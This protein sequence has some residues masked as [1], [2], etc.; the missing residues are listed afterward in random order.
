MPNNL[1]LVGAQ[2]QKPTRWAPLYTGRF[3]SGI[4]TNRSPLRDAATTRNTEKY[5][6]PA[7]D[8]LITGLNTEVTN[9]LTLARRAGTSEYDT[10][11]YTGVDRFYEFRLFDPTTEQI[12]VMVDQ[13][14]AL[15]SLNSGVKSLVFTKSANAG[16]SYMQSVGNILYFA[17]GVDNKKWLQSLTQ[18]TANTLW[19]QPGTPFFTTFLID[20]NGNIQQLTGSVFPITHVT[21]SNNELTITSSATLT[22]LSAVGDI[23][24]FPGAMTAAFLDNK[25][26]TIDSVT[27]NTFTAPFTNPDYSAA[28]TATG[29]AINGGTPTSGGTVPTWSTVVPS[30]SNNFQGGI[31]IDGSVQWTNRG[32]PVENW[33]IAPPTTVL[34]PTK[35]AAFSATWTKNTYYSLAGAI[36]DTN[37]NLQQVTTAGTSSSSVPTWNVTLFGTTTDNG[38]TWTMIQ[39]AAQLVWQAGF[40]YKPPFT[41]SECASAVSGNT[42]YTGV[43]A[44]GAANAYVGMSFLITGFTDLSN[45]GVFNCTASTATTLQLAN[46]AGVAQSATNTASAVHQGT[47]QYVIGNAAGTNCLFKL[48]PATAPALTGSVSAFL[49]AAPHSGPV[50]QFI[51]TNPTSTGSALASSLT[52]NS[53]DFIGTPLGTGSTLAWDTINGAGTVV[54]TTNPFPAFVDNYQLIIEATLNVPVAGQYTFTIVHHDGMIWG[55]GGGVT[56]VSGT[57]NNPIGQ[58]LTAANGYPVLGGTNLSLSGGLE[59]TDTFTVVFPTAGTYPIEIDYDYW[60]HSGQKLNVTCNGNVLANGTVTS[61]SVQPTWPGFNTSFA[62]GYASVSES[63]GGI[64]WNN[65]GPVLD[66]VWTASKGFSLPDSIITDSNGFGEAPYRSGTSGTTQPVWS[67]GLYQLTSDSPNLIWINEGGGSTL[68]AGSLSTFNG[69][70]EYCLALVN[71][72]DNTVSNCTRL[73][74][75]TGN[76]AGLSSI[77]LAPGDGLPP[78]ASIDSQSDY[79]AIFRTTDGQAV[80]FLIP[81][82]STVYTIS[83]A[84]YI[85]NGYTDTTPDTGL[86]N[87]IEGAILGENTPPAQ[88]AKN[89]AYHLNRI[90]YSVGNVVY[91]TSGPDTPVGNGLNGTSPLNFDSMPSLV[92]RIIPTTAGAMIFTVSDVY[93]IQ[94][95]GVANNPLQGAVPILPGIG[96][97]SYNA[98]DIN[99]PLIGLF[100]TDNQ[101]IVL[102]PAGGTDYAGFPIGD[103]FRLNNGTPGQSWNPANVYVAWHVQAEDQGWYICDGVN[104]WYRLMPT[105]SP[106]VGYTWCPF[107]SIVGG[108]KAVQS[109]EVTPGQHRLLIG[110]VTTGSILQRDLTVF[111]DNGT[112]YPANAVIGSLVLAQP[113]QIATVDFISIDSVRIGTPMTLGILID[114]AL[115]YYQGPMDVL[116]QWVNDPPTLRPSRS[117]YNQRFYLSQT[118]DES[119]AM[120]HMQIKIQWS[121]TDTVQN[122]AQTMTIFGTFMQE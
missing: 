45:N 37:G 52:L 109:V 9:R 85:A 63:A 110:P 11:S 117:F 53:L 96:L 87:L 36:I 47:I 39:T 97:L 50:G 19:N 71:T 81:G 111:S 30:S 62:P 44:G 2:A 60:Y 73:S 102:N 86:N 14:N 26:V 78:L 4:W 95:N 51:L 28:E 38:V 114:D 59:W 46:G 33:G 18:W 122:E 79:V 72:L 20:P 64:V 27:T 113:G 82:V 15:Y 34:S 99:G 49:Y 118:A 6:G 3:S 66:F 32:L 21:I 116:K 67:Q 24:T 88:G 48:A 31:T 41:L 101:F 43:I 10:N 12:N 91:W 75:S 54:G 108:A 106:E 22:S 55:M 100:T 107:A 80:P 92:T 68:P 98:L 17:D 8:A 76:F 77:S 119:S 94:G 121:E 105:P 40:A 7:G 25:T 84:N 115:P 16:Q 13:A 1:G 65:I 5:Y 42:V 29:T 89:L 104:G 61:G 103:Q 74:A 112:A 58:T 69:G 35:G 120:R 56:L 93:L 70:W 57:S 23:I 90:F 83:L